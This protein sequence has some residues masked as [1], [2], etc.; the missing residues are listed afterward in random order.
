MALRLKSFYKYLMI[1]LFFGLWE[2]ACRMGI[3]NNLFIPPFSEIVVAT[4]N[5]AVSD[6][7]MEH[8][9]ISL[10]RAVLGFMAAI[11][12]GIPLGFLLGGWFKYLQLALTPIVEIFSQTNPFILFHILILFLGIGELPKI[13]II[14]WACIWPIVFNTVQGIQHVNPVVLKAGRGFGLGR[15]KLFYKIVLPS[16]SPSIFT[17]L[18]LS[19]G[20]SLFML[21]AAEMMGGSSGLG[22]L[23]KSSEENYEIQKIFSAALVIAFLG[24]IIDLLMYAVERKF[25]NRV[26]EDILNNEY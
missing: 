15:F 1:V 12:I 24:M 18:R 6:N 3:L 7:L 22:W 25:M 21:I 19:A 10:Q 14:G 13:A 26:E 9:L 20:Y 16:V 11:I 4:W 2:L 17:G 23:I 5:L 8:I